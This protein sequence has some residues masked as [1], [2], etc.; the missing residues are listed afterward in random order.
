MTTHLRPPGPKLGR[1]SEYL[2]AL[3]RRDIL[4]F[5]L[6]LSRE[7]GDVTS[8]RAGGQRYFLLNHPDYIRDVL[9]T[10]Q[11]N[12]LKGRGSQRRAQFLGD[13]I[14]IAE[15]EVHRRQR[16]LMQ[17]A[18][19]RQR[20]AAYADVMIEQGALARERWRDGETFDVAQEMRRITIPI[21]SR[22]LFH[23]ET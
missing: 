17:P 6:G 10:H 14:I 3:R 5:M 18:F 9:I 13:G 4:G 16:R 8:F 2:L 22:T 1:I 11:E 21:V 19:H 7:Y 12:F 20:I 15:G 23:T